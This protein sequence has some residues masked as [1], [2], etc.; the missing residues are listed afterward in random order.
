MIDRIRL[1]KHAPCTAVAKR[2]RLFAGVLVLGALQVVA[3]RPGPGAGRR[4]SQAKVEKAAAAPASMNAPANDAQESP[5]ERQTQR[6]PMLTLDPLQPWF[7]DRRGHLALTARRY[8]QYERARGL[9]LALAADPAVRPKDRRGAQ[10]LLAYSELKKG[11]HAPAARRLQKLW[12]APEF[13][14]IADDLVCMGVRAWLDA[15]RPAMAK[16]LLEQS[17]EA[18]LNSPRL[19]LLRAAIAIQGSK[20]REA[21]ALLEPLTQSQDPAVAHSA[22]VKLAS[23]LVQGGSASDKERAKDLLA[24][25]E[26]KQLSA[27]GQRQL[28]RLQT[29]LSPEGWPTQEVEA[30]SGRSAA[31]QDVER[32]Y[33]ARSYRSAKRAADRRLRKRRSLKAAELC[34]LYYWKGSSIFK[35]RDR[36]GSASSFANGVKYCKKAKLV[37]LEV[38]CR[39]Q[40]ARGIYAQGRYDVAAKQFETLARVHAKHSYA[41]DALVFAGE[42]WESAKNYRRAIASYE[43]A[44]SHK[45]K[46]DMQPEARRRLMLLAFS[47]NR[48]KDV[49]ALVNKSLASGDE[50]KVKE[51]AKLLYF[52]GRAYDR[53]G[54]SDKATADYLQ[55][56]QTLPLSYPAIHAWSR[57]RERDPKQW[58]AQLH[59]NLVNAPVAAAPPV[60]V[61]ADAE[62]QSALLWA[63]LGVASKAKEAL[64]HAG[65]DG[66]PEIAILALAGDWWA[67]QRSVS[68]LGN[69]WRRSPP[70]DQMRPHWE[71]AHPMVFKDL[72]IAREEAAELPS[73]LAFAIMQ[74]ES[75]FDPSVTSWAGAKGLMQLMPG[76]ADFI[77]KKLG[78]RKPSKAALHQPELN[79][80]MGVYNLSSLVGRYGGNEFSAALAIPGYNAGP[81]NVDK[82]L[83]QRADWDLDLFIEAIP[84]DETRHY[85]QSVLGRWLA[86][87]WIYGDQA[88]EERIPYLPL[89][90]PKQAG[91]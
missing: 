28:A 81:G 80:Q 76:T 59:K 85:T 65:V 31:V 2:G 11:D 32:L 67:S 44:L 82:W 73:L 15:S 22:K 26:E 46:G 12:N 86:Y 71:L 41:D 56:V 70:K 45:P 47:Q 19:A 21:Q 63:Q 78:L 17:D 42:A 62:G 52:R 1:L 5:P 79:I 3:C 66:W 40:G 64:R 25:V 29:I 75:R 4:Q 43:K 36:A 57:L 77:A 18:G 90:T 30:K 91:R 8:G 20:T 9:L 14:V 6:G 89:T 37:D 50:V 23:I 49:I 53:Q 83:D 38:K 74:T 87:R 54:H 13:G 60:Q 58:T 51:R 16:R 61:P 34:E 24:L 7:E 10:L 72:V 68:N 55:V 27:A 33:R 39:Y 35:S 84:F 88:P 69:E 48:L